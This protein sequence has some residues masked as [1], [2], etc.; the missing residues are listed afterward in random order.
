MELSVDGNLDYHVNGTRKRKSNSDI[1]YENK[2]GIEYWMVT[3]LESEVDAMK[4]FILNQALYDMTE[5]ITE[6]S[7]GKKDVKKSID[8]LNELAASKNPNLVR[9]CEVNYMRLYGDELHV[10]TSFMPKDGDMKMKVDCVGSPTPGALYYGECRYEELD[11]CKAV[12]LKNVA[13]S[14]D[15]SIGELMKQK[16]TVE[17]MMK[18]LP[19]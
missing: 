12:I 4:P 17:K 5:R 2:D 19:A 9:W 1:L 3:C 7:N 10:E 14:I 11:K 15:K 16:N 6:T 8:E 18:K 13:D